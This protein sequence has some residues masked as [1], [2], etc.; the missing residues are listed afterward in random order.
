MIFGWFKKLRSIRRA[1]LRA[2]DRHLL[3]PSI[4]RTSLT[5]AQAIQAFLI[6][7]SV[8]PAWID[9]LPKEEILD[10]VRSWPYKK[11]S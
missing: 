3:W 4:V 8:D 11:E 6:H 2:M 9:E 1:Q 7:A 10:I 5:R